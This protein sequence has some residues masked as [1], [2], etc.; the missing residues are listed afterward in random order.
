[1]RASGAVAAGGVRLGLGLLPLQAPAA[2][3]RT[4]AAHPREWGRRRV[5]AGQGHGTAL[6]G[7]ARL[8]SLRRIAA[9][10]GGRRDQE[11]GER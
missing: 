5:S 3:P 2:H 1:M 10:G 11:Q 4:A 6:G 8:P 7:C 9:Q